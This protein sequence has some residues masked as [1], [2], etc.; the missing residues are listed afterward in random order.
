[1]SHLTNLCQKPES[2]A[3]G[4]Q[5]LAD[6]IAIVRREAEKRTG[7]SESDPLATKVEELKKQKKS[8]GGKRNV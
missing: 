3:N 1:M 5:A 2:A 4:H 7:A 8:N 6:Y